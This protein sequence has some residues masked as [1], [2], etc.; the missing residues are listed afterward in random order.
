MFRRLISIFII[1]PLAV[2]LIALAVANRGAVPLRF[3]VFNPQNP[4]LTVHAPMFIWLLG[5][6][7]LGVIAGG[8]GTW[9]T[10]GKHRK[11]ER[12]YK[13]EAQSLRYEVEDTKRK[14]GGEAES[15]KPLLLSR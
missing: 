12:R 4:A 11:L 14:T 3:D 13:K 1:I 9:L 8:L 10:Q 5:A 15:G 6:V 7:A 2:V